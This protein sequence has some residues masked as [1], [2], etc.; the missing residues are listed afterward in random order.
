M[1]TVMMSSALQTPVCRPSRIASIISRPNVVRPM[2][3]AVVVRAEKGGPPPTVRDLI[4]RRSIVLAAC[5]RVYSDC[6]IPH[7]V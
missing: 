7:S 3:S 5:C 6:Q 1:Q 2:R 4:H